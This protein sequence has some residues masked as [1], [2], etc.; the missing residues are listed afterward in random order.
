MVEGKQLKKEK[1]F[2]QVL[3][4]SAWVDGPTLL[5]SCIAQPHCFPQFPSPK[6]GSK[7]HGFDPRMCSSDRVWLQRHSAATFLLPVAV[8]VVSFECLSWNSHVPAEE[9]LHHCSEACPVLCEVL[10]HCSEACPVLC[11]VLHH[12]SEDTVNM[13]MHS[14]NTQRH[15]LVNHWSRTVDGC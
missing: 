11:E 15:H 10:H 12:C 7:N 3:Q 6:S 9:V 5:I 2:W 8:L 13:I 14:F 4:L 1:H